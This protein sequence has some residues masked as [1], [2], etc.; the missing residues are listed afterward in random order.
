MDLGL[1]NL[2]YPLRRALEGLLPRLKGVDPNA[3]TWCVLP[4]GAAT[5]WAAWIGAHGDRRAWIA[6]IA[7][8]F[9]RMFLATLDG[10][11]AQSLGRETRTGAVL[12]RFVPE[13][14]DTM[15]IGALAFAWPEWRAWGLGALAAGWLTTFA[16]L[17]GATVNLPIQSVGPVGQTDRLAA[18]QA[19][20]LVACF[21]PAAGWPW[22]PMKLFLAWCVIGGA[23]T[24]ALRMRRQF[25]GAKAVA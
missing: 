3:V 20:A 10:L 7:L 6:A 8:V 9:V 14:S 25:A 22:P 18:F 16:G 2:K 19:F 15:L 17:V 4:V 21:E 24:V 13:L 5:A 11:M 23:A 1:Y 12:N